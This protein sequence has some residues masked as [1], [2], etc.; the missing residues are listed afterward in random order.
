MGVGSSF[1][2]RGK[3]KCKGPEVS[4]SLAYS[5]GNKKTGEDG[6]VEEEESRR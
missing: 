6:A 4:M 3:S 2:R 5:W 1:P